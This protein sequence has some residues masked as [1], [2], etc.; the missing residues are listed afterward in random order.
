L[1]KRLTTAAKTIK[2]EEI[3]KMAV[4]VA[5]S[6]PQA[7]LAAIKRAIEQRHVET[8][9]YDKDGDFTHTP[10]QWANKCWLRPHFGSGV[11]TFTTLPPRGVAL[12]KEIYAVYHG[13]FIEMLLAHFDSQ[14]ADAEATAVGTTQDVV[15]AS[16]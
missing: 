5:T 7:L 13:R 11:L 16:A 8:W 6:Q 9:T 4:R 2:T 3:S 10:T 14:F 15:R 12:S 1:G